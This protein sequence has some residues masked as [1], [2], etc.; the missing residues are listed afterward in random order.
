MT[1]WVVDGC[2]DPSSH[3]WVIARPP[4]TAI[5]A[6]AAAATRKDRRG[7]RRGVTTGGSVLVVAAWAR[8]LPRRAGATEASWV[9]LDGLG[10]FMLRRPRRW[11]TLTTEFLARILPMGKGN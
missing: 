5:T 2:W 9:P 4:P 3:G 8:M 6:A 11:R 7:V 10:H 1:C